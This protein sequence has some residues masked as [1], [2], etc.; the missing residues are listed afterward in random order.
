[1]TDTPTE[2]IEPNELAKRRRVHQLT[3]EIADLMKAGAERFCE[4][5]ELGVDTRDVAKL[6][7]DELPPTARELLMQSDALAFS[8]DSAYLNLTLPPPKDLAE[9]AEQAKKM[10]AVM[11][12]YY[13]GGMG[14]APDFYSQANA[15]I[16]K[17]SRDPQLGWTPK[18]RVIERLFE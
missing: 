15:L 2:Q 7:G 10:S 8:L 4:L 3:A 12:K 11:S 1:M 14:I 5:Q 18:R 13:D 17:K 16:E 9:R 6:V